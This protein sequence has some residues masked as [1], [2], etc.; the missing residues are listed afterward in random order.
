MSDIRYLLL[1]EPLDASVHQF[2]MPFYRQYEQAI[3]SEKYGPSRFPMMPVRLVDFSPECP[4][5]RVHRS[6]LNYLAH[7]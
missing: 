7:N 5:V 3:E 2:L 1:P 4:E 6:D